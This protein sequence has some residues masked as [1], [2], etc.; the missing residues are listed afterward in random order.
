MKNLK[1]KGKFIRP[2][3]VRVRK[4]PKIEELLE[5][6]NNTPNFTNAKEMNKIINEKG[7]TPNWNFVI[8]KNKDLNINDFKKLGN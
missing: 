7:K 4:G 5:K 2:Q 8:L 6:S 3:R 1:Y